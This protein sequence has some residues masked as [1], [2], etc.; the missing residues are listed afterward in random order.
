M[1]TARKGPQML[2]ASVF[3]RWGA[4]AIYKYGASD[5]RF[6]QLRPNDA[7]IWQAI[8]WALG[9][10]CHS[11]SMGKTSLDHEGLRQFKMGWGA[12]EERIGYYRYAL[13]SA[14]VAVVNDALNGWHN[15]MF[16]VMPLWL[17]RTVGTLLYR[18]IA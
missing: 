15:H 18:H 2:A 5:M 14:R 8:C 1:V 13:P 4:H 9:E 10:S 16:R 11:L 3:F 17:S 12:A 6:Q 7:V